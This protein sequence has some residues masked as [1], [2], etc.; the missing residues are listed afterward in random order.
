MWVRFRL[1]L[2]PSRSH[3]P[4]TRMLYPEMDSWG[5]VAPVRVKEDKIN[6]DLLHPIH[7]RH[8]SKALFGSWPHGHGSESPSILESGPDPSHFGAP[9]PKRAALL[10]GSGRNFSWSLADFSRLWLIVRLKFWPD[11]VATDRVVGEGRKP[12]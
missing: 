3:T 7:T 2:E 12:C 4:P 11:R 8:P 6:R 5:P 1:D 9:A 10:N